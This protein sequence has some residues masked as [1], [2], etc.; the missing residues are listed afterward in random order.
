MVD[1]SHEHRV[2]I[3]PAEVAEAVNKA[4]SL[5]ALLALAEEFAPSKDAI[6]LAIAKILGKATE[7]PPMSKDAGISTP[8]FAAVV[9]P[10]YRWVDGHSSERTGST[11]FPKAPGETAI[12]TVPDGPFIQT[13]EGRLIRIHELLHARF[14]PEIDA[15]ARVFAQ[16]TPDKRISPV[17]LEVGEDVRLHALANKLGVFDGS[18]YI[19]DLTYHEVG[20][21]RDGVPPIMHQVEMAKMFM[22]AYGLPTESGWSTKDTEGYQRATGVTFSR[23]SRRVLKAWVN[24]IE[25]AL[26]LPDAYAQFEK[27]SASTQQAIH[28]LLTP[29]PPGNGGESEE[30]ATGGGSSEGEGKGDSGDGDAHPTTPNELE[31]AMKAAARDYVAAIEAND[32]VGRDAAEQRWNKANQQ[33]QACVRLL[34]EGGY[35]E[36]EALKDWTPAF[37]QR[38]E[39]VRL[40]T[41]AEEG[42]PDYKFSPSLVPHRSQ[43]QFWDSERPDEAL[44]KNY[45]LDPLDRGWHLM[46]MQ[47]GPLERNF[48]AVVHRKGIA[49]PE[50][51]IPKFFGRWFSDKQLFERKGRRL[52]GTLLIDVSGSM[53][54][55]HAQTLALIEATP[56][57]TI[58]V[59]SSNGRL[60]KPGGIDQHRMLRWSQAN[61]HAGHDD[62]MRFMRDNQV[63]GGL[64]TI[65]AQHGKL[66]GP[67][68]KLHGNHTDD[69]CAGHGGGNEVDGPALSWLARQSQPRV[70]FSDGQVTGAGEVGS[71]Q[72]YADSRRLQRLGN[73]VRTTNKDAV[74]M[75]FSGRPG[76][77]ALEDVHLPGA[78]GKS[79]DKYDD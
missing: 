17:A 51:P 9:Q 28:L 2:A 16:Q 55:S 79:G 60:D 72:L 19:S 41:K 78:A 24:T 62:M 49:S 73:I 10:E 15:R 14:T 59:Y 54:W 69:E 36:S 67:N 34:E 30:D 18:A 5:S 56:A 46:G 23:R 11:T 65:I 58:A 64:L 53:G 35:D 8:T 40:E 20:L 1:D 76:W 75:I 66:V 70:W 33:V 47:L 50:G 32:K 42:I 38:Q 7:R 39:I 44:A 13:P 48:K 77:H 25:R 3:T 27:L 61:P 68:Y 22:S 71:S 21:E 45:T 63:S 57:M 26:T 52:G 43:Y 6:R 31:A 74:E 29:P 12:M 37:L 4:G